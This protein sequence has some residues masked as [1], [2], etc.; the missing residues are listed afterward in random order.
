MGWAQGRPWVFKK[1][2]GDFPDS[3]VVETLTSNAGGAGSIPG[4]ELRP[5]MLWGV[6]KNSKCRVGTRGL[7]MGRMQI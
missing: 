1:D 7:N 3:P 6:V 5:H 4:R 2:Y